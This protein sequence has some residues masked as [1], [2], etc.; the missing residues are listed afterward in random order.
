MDGDGN[1]LFLHQSTGIGDTIGHFAVARTRFRV[2]RVVET[3]HKRLHRGASYFH[4]QHFITTPHAASHQRI[5]AAVSA[6]HS[7]SDRLGDWVHYC[8]PT[9]LNVSDLVRFLQEARTSPEHL[10][11]FSGHSVSEGTPQRLGARVV[12]HAT[13]IACLSLLSFFLFAL[14]HP[15]VTHLS[16]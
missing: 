7:R 14:P 6:F 2:Q 16:L 13:V 8:P 11:S 10:V 15:P 3:L 4:A 12:T 5:S 9:L 1:A